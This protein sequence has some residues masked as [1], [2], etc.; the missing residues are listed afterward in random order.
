MSHFCLETETFSFYLIR[1]STEAVHGHD[2]GGYQWSWTWPRGHGAHSLLGSFSVLVW[3]LH[4][5]C[6]KRLLQDAT[7]GQAGMSLHF[8]ART[9]VMNL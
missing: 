8:H 5:F 9:Q 4:E 3:I 2:A 6:C 7:L 1:C